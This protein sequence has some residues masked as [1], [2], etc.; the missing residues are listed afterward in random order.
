[1]KKSYEGHEIVYK[2]MMRVGVRSWDEGID[3]KREEIDKDTKR[4]LEDVLS[5]P[6]TPKNGKVLELGC[7][8]GPMLRWVCKRGFSGV[9]IDISKTAITM[10]KEQSKGLDIK[11]KQ[12]DV[13]NLNTKRYGKFDIVI[14]GH[15]LHCITEKRDRTAYL[16]NAFELLKNN[17]LFILLSMCS[18]ID[19]KI[20]ETEC[21]NQIF[22]NHTVYT[23]FEKGKEFEGHRIIKG[24]GYLPTRKVPHWNAILGEIKRAGFKIKLLRYNE[25]AGEDAF[26]SLTIGAL[27]QDMNIK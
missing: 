19:K 14:D 8:T 25:A 12:D 2:R 24:Q 20:F 5:Q 23:P 7:G 21:R 11:F 27:K 26:S 17:G 15:C 18:P 4:F 13:C 3:P 16:Q 6:W 22:L 9:G 1:M 10:A